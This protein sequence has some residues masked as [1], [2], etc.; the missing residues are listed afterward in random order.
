M[1]QDLHAHVGHSDLI[2]IRESE[3]KPVSDLLG[4]LD[5]RIDLPANV[6]GRFFYLFQ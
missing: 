1:I 4:I 2:G 3:S 6:A 5:H